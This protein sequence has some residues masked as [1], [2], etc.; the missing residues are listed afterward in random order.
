MN[1]ED[2]IA[3]GQRHADFPEKE[4]VTKGFADNLSGSRQPI[5][6]IFYGKNL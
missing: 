2:T 5:A 3:V 6:K 1:A 4:L